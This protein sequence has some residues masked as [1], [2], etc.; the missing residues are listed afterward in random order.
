MFKQ[1]HYLWIMIL[2]AGLISCDSGPKVI[3]SE[4]E[5]GSSSSTG[6]FNTDPPSQSPGADQ[7]P[8]V[9]T[10]I[11]TIKVLEVLPTDKYV[12]MRAEEEGEEFWVATSKQEVEVGETY[13]F[14][15]GLLKTN[16]ESKEYNRVFD[17]V[18]L[19]SN[20]VPAN[21]SAT[22]MA[23]SSDQEPA[24]KRPAEEIKPANTGPIEVEGSITIQD[25]VNNKEQYANQEVQVSGRV[26]KVNPNIMERNWV[27]IQDG[28]MDDYD[29]VFTTQQ[30]IP[31]GAIITVKGKV[32]LDRDFGA[33]YRYDLIVEDAVLAK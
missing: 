28:S 6:I 27:H 20:I 13:Y 8:A 22:A 21:H 4:K 11:H 17:K 30:A 2:F 7:M 32:S 26:T 31:E 10:E 33:G 3:A 15:K 23:N 5:G 24:T 9:N 18:Y 29:F 1:C 25:L 19:V 16:F 12:Y 14:K